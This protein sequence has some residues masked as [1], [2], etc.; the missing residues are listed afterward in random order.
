MDMDGARL[1]RSILSLAVLGLLGVGLVNAPI[2]AAKQPSGP[3]VLQ[4]KWMRVAPGLLEGAVS[5]RYLAVVNS[6]QQLTLIDQQ[7]GKRTALFPPD[8]SGP[9]TNC[10]DTTQFGG[11]WLMVGCD[12]YNLNIGRWT[13]FRV[14]SKCPNAC[15]VV[16]V[17]R[18]WLKL[19]SPTGYDPYAP[20]PS[21]WLQSISSG[22]VISDPIS[23]GGAVFDDLNTPSGSVP[24]CAPL[25]YPIAQDRFIYP[26]GLTFYGPGPNQFALT[27]EGPGGPNGTF[28]MR[29]CHSSLNLVLPN[30]A[31]GGV[32]PMA[33][34]SAV[35]A[36]SNGG[37]SL[38]GWTLPSLRRF[39]I[40]WPR[41]LSCG[42][43]ITLDVL[44]KRYLYVTVD[45]RAYSTPVPTAR[46]L[47]QRN[48][49]RWNP[50]P[51]RW[52]L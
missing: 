42:D 9:N 32:A 43:R 18:Y 5:D 13:T 37:F 51:Q 29:R 39:T 27:D 48:H 4:P 52:C 6:Q 1:R 11:P 2:V 19:A 23:P 10:P 21:L 45:G 24:L 41:Q 8:G 22:Q 46:D 7:T 38:Y 20:P 35:I 44:T 28:R 12:L 49:P 34:S 14:S 15:E 3:V 26:G 30:N 47:A 25:R 36:E 17:G 40:L 50:A 33:S 31:Y 16:G